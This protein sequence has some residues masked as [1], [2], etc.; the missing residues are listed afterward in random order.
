MTSRFATLSIC[1]AASAACATSE[2]RPAPPGCRSADC[3]AIG[4]MQRLAADLVVTPLEV[5]ED[6]RCP[7][8]A[9]CVWSGRVVL[10]SQLDLGHETIT[11]NLDSIEPLTING[12]TLTIAEVAPEMSNKWIPIQPE[13][14]RFGFAFAPDGD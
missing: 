4:E 7:I 9:E 11:T 10:R 3:V 5:I 1:L 14:Y 6:S 12:G 2:E 8:E 13:D